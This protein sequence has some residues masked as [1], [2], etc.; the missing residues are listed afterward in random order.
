[1]MKRIILASL[2]VWAFA[3]TAMAQTGREIAQK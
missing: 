2:V 3:A 1:M